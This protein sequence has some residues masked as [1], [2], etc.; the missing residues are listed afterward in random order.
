MRLLLTAVTVFAFSPFAALALYY[1]FPFLLQWASFS[2]FAYVALGA[3][4][5]SYLAH[6]S[7]LKRFTVYGIL[8][9]LFTLS[10]LWL[11]DIFWPEMWFAAPVLF[12]LQNLGMI[13]C[14]YGSLLLY[15]FLNK[16]KAQQAA[17]M[18]LNNARA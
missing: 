3:A 1:V 16:F 2:S 18:D 12:S 4:C 14:G 6:I 8:Y 11:P 5:F 15:R 10:H 9:V 13:I 17:T 7:G